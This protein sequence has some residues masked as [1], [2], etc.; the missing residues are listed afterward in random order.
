MQITI[1]N[2]RYTPKW[3]TLDKLIKECT[4]N[5]RAKIIGI[6]REDKGCNYRAPGVYSV[7]IDQ[8]VSTPENNDTVSTLTLTVKGVG[9][10]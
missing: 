10:Q 1:T 9:E 4:A 8:G 7:K 6:Q 3:T 2:C 5:D